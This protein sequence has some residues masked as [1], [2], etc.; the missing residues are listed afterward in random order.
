MKKNGVVIV[1]YNRLNLL[2]ECLSAVFAQVYPFT[3]II[4]VNNASTDGTK[5]YLDSLQSTEKTHLSVIHSA[6]NLGGSGGFYL[7]METARAKGFDYLLIIDDDAII[8]PDYMKRLIE[9]ADNHTNE[10]IEALAGAVMLN[11]KIDITHRRTVNNKLLFTEPPVSEINYSKDSFRCDTAT[12]CGLLIRGDV[13]QRIG[14]PKK[15]YFLWYDDTEYSLRLKGITVIP[16]AKLNHKTKPAPQNASLLERST[17]RHYYGYRNRYDTARIHF[18]LSSTLCIS[19][20]YHILSL[21]SRLMWLNPQKR[22][23]AKYNIKM[24]RDALNDAKSGKLGKNLKYT[25]NTKI[26]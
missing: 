15:E 6:E 3:E 10:N 9:Y 4:V 14:L 13:F 17:W 21:L 12:F 2:K 8:Q 25:P 7:G 18:G 23:I 16:A 19:L 1:T 22:K 5:E 26:D 11:G 24:I 20:E